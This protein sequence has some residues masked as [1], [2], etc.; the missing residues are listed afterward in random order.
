MKKERYFLCK[1]TGKPRSKRTTLVHVVAT[2]VYLGKLGNFM[3][4]YIPGANWKL[5]L[6]TFSFTKGSCNTWSTLEKSIRI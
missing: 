2:D 6:G 3:V 4:Q 1:I 5:E